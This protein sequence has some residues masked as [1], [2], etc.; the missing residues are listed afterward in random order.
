MTESEQSSESLFTPSAGSSYFDTYKQHAVR[1]ALRKL[2][3]LDNQIGMAIRMRFGT[4][5]GSPK[6][7]SDIAARFGI[8]P[9][10]AK[11]IITRGLRLLKSDPAL[12]AI[13]DED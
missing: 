3:S 4:N 11:R 7:Y 12:I 10:D 1:E 9:D 8:K 5:G 6:S 2:D 13:N